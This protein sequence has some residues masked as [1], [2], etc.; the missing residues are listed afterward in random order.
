MVLI[1]SQ[2][3]WFNQQKKKKK[4]SVN[5][6]GSLMFSHRTPSWVYLFGL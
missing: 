6:V 3:L 2:D 5:V 4:K 1:Y